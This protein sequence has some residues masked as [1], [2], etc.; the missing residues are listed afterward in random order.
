MDKIIRYATNFRSLTIHATRPSFVHTVVYRLR[1]LFAPSL[2]EFCIEMDEDS[3]IQE[4]WSIQETSSDPRVYKSI[5]EGGVPSLSSIKVHG[6]SLRSCWPPLVAITTLRLSGDSDTYLPIGYHRFAK[7]LAALESLDHLSLLGIVF[8]IDAGVD[9]IA[10][11]M[12]SLHSLVV[13]PWNYRGDRDEV[14]Y[15]VRLFES[16]IAPGLSSLALRPCVLGQYNAFLESLRLHSSPKYPVLRSLTVES[17]E[18]GDLPD[19]TFFN[20]FPALQHFELSRAYYAEALMDLF[21][22]WDGKSSEPG[23][24]PFCP[25]LQSMTLFIS[26]VFSEVDILLAKL[27]SFLGSCSYETATPEIGSHRRTFSTVYV[28]LQP[29]T[30]R[31][32]T[33]IRSGGRG[34]AIR[35]E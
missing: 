28:H 29:P 9:A 19:I 4:A 30:V 11:E 3:S 22:N 17:L 6:I 13:Q 32:F 7:M 2:Q 15:T 23:A 16:V 25:D 33:S 34:E 18:K 5:F 35:Y 14:D 12:P 31:Q 26:P 8:Q 24:T 21:I 1:S 10:V 20:A 27:H